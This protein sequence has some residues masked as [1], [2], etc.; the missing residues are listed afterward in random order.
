MNDF[1]IG[2]CFDFKNTFCLGVTDS[3]V[4]NITQFALHVQTLKWLRWEN[5]VKRLII[6]YSLACFI[7]DFSAFVSA[8]PFIMFDTC[9]CCCCFFILHI[10]NMS[11]VLFFR[12]GSCCFLFFFQFKLLAWW[13]MYLLKNYCSWCTLF[14]QSF[15][16]SLGQGI[17][18]TLKIWWQLSCCSSVLWY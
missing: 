17:E 3:V 15:Y 8:L 13:K 18:M 6:V 7:T 1:G 11:F 12:R 4:T 10:F 9:L 2:S 14:L 16:F 5:L